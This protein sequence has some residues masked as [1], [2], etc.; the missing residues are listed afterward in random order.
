M[1]AEAVRAFSKLI[2]PA[3]SLLLAFGV[4]LSGLYVGDLRGFRL[5]YLVAFFIVFLSAIGSYAFNDYCDLEVDKRNNRYDRPLVLKL[6]PRRVALMT[7]LASFS[8]SLLFSLLL[9]PLAMS[10]VLV[11]LPLFFLYSLG[12]KRIFLVKNAL[13]AYACV[14]PILFGALVSDAILEPLIVYLAVI[15]FIAGWIFEIMMDIGDVK[16]DK[17]QGI[18]TLSTRFGVKTAAQVSVVLYGAITIL[19]FLPFFVMID[20]RLYLD[21]A[22]LLLILILVVSRFFVVKPLMKDQSKENV[23]QL[24]KRAFVNLQM[25]CMAYLIGILL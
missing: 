13:I 24:Q 18:E 8:L 25:S 9:N 4:I 7:T 21:Y 1:G 2:R 22:F 12:I 16:G 19:N 20:P 5:E 17:E 10:L 15:V 3:R 6:L 23:F 11:S 14:A